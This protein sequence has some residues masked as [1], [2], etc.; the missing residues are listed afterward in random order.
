VSATSIVK[1]VVFIVVEVIL[2]NALLNVVTSLSSNSLANNILIIGFLVLGIVG[3]PIVIS[4]L[5]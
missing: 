3:I 4:K 2:I 1:A 5:F